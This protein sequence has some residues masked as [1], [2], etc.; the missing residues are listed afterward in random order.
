MFFMMLHECSV[1]IDRPLVTY[2][3]NNHWTFPWHVC[4][5]SIKHLTLSICIVD[6]LETLGLGVVMKFLCMGCQPLFDVIN[7]IQQK[8]SGFDVWNTVVHS[9]KHFYKKKETCNSALRLFYMY[10]SITAMDNTFFD[11]TIIIIFF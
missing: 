5:V 4:I 9:F 3:Q 11:E 2:L 1:L 10:P 8:C 7:H 6:K